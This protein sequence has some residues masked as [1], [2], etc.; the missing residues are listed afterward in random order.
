MIAHTQYEFEACVKNAAGVAGRSRDGGWVRATCV[1]EARKLHFQVYSGQ[2][3]FRSDP[4]SRHV[5]QFQGFVVPAIVKACFD[6]ASEHHA[7]L[8]ITSPVG[9]YA[10]PKKSRGLEC[11]IRSLGYVGSYLREYSSAKQLLSGY[12]MS[13]L[14]P[15]IA[16]PSMGGTI[17]T[18]V[19]FNTASLD[20]AK[21]PLNPGQR[22][23]VEEL[24][25]GLDIIVG[26]PGGS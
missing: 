13:P 17:G 7:T 5:V 9:S 4:W 1:E 10:M 22:R 16:C 21:V 6:G 18:F 3:N 26:P 12:I 15:K 23:A 25:G 11:C 20:M 24:R 2:H 8:V 19:P 14:L